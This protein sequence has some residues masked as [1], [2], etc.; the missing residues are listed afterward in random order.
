MVDPHAAK[1]SAPPLPPSPVVTWMCQGL[2]LLA[3]VGPAARYQLRGTDLGRLGDLSLLVQGLALAVALFL[4]LRAGLLATFSLS[5][6]LPPLR[7]GLALGMI[8]L[9][10]LG[11]FV[12]LSHVTN[13]D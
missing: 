5:R 8:G 2:G 11:V 7:L 9:V 13:W 6:P 10:A 3:V 4:L 12:D 1:P